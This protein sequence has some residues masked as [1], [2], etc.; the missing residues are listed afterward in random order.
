MSGRGVS[1]LLWLAAVVAMVGAACWQRLTGP[2]YPKRGSAVVAGRT[3]TYRLLRTGV[4]GRPLPV[5]VRAPSG[6]DGSVHFRR[7]PTAEPFVAV[8]MRREGDALAAELP[9]QP[10]AGKLEYYVTLRSPEG[11]TR[12]PPGEPAVMRFKGEVAA[13]VLVP[14]I[15]MMFLSMVI[16]LRA[17]LAA[18]FRRPEA[19]RY[20]WVA[21]VGITLGGLVLGPLVQKQAFGAYWTGWP[22]GEDLTDTKTLAMCGAWL[23]AVVALGRWRDPADRRA[24][25]ATVAAA[26][27]MIAVYLVPHSL[28]G[29][30]LDYSKLDAGAPAEHG[31]PDRR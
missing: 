15:V 28:R 10:P 6:V 9:S 24:R 12:L 18:V 22:L 16:G 19:R 13:A 11:E 23:V 1:A 26:L 14:H 21:L 7:F 17:G 5:T 31:V 4:S 8:P 25:G 30:Q 3:L 27:V 29:S 2:T 20:A